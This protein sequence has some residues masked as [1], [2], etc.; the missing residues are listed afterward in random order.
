MDDAIQHLLVKRDAPRRFAYTASQVSA[1][2]TWLDYH[3]PPLTSPCSV[4]RAKYTFHP[5]PSHP[6]P[7]DPRALAMLHPPSHSFSGS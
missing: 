1:T 3:Y 2:L 6:I 7:T 5:I 4:T